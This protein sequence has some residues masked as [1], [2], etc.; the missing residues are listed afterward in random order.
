[1]EQ[2]WADFGPQFFVPGPVSQGT[3]GGQTAAFWSKDNGG[4]SGTLQGAD[5]EDGSLLILLTS[6]GGGLSQDD[7]SQIGASLT[8][9]T[10]AS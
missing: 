7:I 1:M 8:E 6:N 3:V 4:P 9:G 5:W 2:P 10:T